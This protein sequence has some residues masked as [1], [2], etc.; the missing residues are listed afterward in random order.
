MANPYVGELRL[1][2]FD[3]APLGWAQAQGQLMAISQNTALFSLLGTYYG[4]NGT[5]TFGLPNL[6]GNLAVG[7][8]QGIGLSPYELG[9]SGGSQTVTMLAA[10]VPSHSH[11]FQADSRLANSPSP[12]GEAL[13]RTS[14]DNAIY[15]SPGSGTLKQ[16]N[17]N[18]LSFFGGSQPH[19]NMMP[20]LALNWVIALQGVFPPRS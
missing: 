8:G 17:Q 15:A 19:N 16:M 2:G 20:V 12:S 18:F 7:A 1:V 3:F 10:N 6:Q 4:G 13:A 14:D 5:S 9:E 11:T